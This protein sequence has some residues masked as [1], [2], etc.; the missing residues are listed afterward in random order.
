MIFLI[1]E[2]IFYATKI[3]N[4]ISKIINRF[5]LSFQQKLK[6]KFQVV[7]TIHRKNKIVDN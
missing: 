2:F 3:F 5:Q 6:V 1:D 4:S 7:F